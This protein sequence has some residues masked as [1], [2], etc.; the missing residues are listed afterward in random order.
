MENTN[1]IINDVVENVVEALPGDKEKPSIASLVILGFALIGV[2]A[3]GYFTYKGIKYV[4]T[5]L[6]DGS[7]KVEKASKKKEANKEAAK[8]EAKEE[9]A[10]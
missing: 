2:G 3:T 8:E 1:E 9:S 4:V 6:K 5:K 7:L 10:E